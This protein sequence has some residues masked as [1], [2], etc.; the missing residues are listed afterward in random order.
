MI[1]SRKQVP[2]GR[3]LTA[4]LFFCGESCQSFDSFLIGR[5]G[6]NERHKTGSYRNRVEY[7]ANKADNGGGII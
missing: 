7:G 1:R 4:F 2:M 3:Q 5:M 6:E